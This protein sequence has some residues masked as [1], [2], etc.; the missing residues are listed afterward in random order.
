MAVNDFLRTSLFSKLTKEE[1]LQVQ[2]FQVVS[3]GNLPKFFNAATQS[4]GEEP[5]QTIS[6]EFEAFLILQSLNNPDVLSE[7][8]IWFTEAAN[9]Q[10]K[11]SDRDD[12]LEE[13]FNAEREDALAKLQETRSRT[14]RFNRF[15]AEFQNVE[16][17]AEE[18]STKFPPSRFSNI[19]EIGLI[20][21]DSQA[22]MGE[23][24]FDQRRE[25]H[26]LLMTEV[27][28]AERISRRRA[29][30]N[31]GGIADDRVAEELLSWRDVLSTMQSRVSGV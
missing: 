2:R 29:Q 12:L 17:G 26:R 3:A 16:V 1:R 7:A 8:T 6:R 24:A 10:I 14:V 15:R 18:D 28:N 11:R 30:D 23:I 19:T 25:E 31:V 20:I 9:F 4:V 22:A 5:K 27:L 21:R 13:A